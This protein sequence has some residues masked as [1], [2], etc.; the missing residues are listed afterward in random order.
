MRA[1]EQVFV[2]IPGPELDAES[3]R[4]LSTL[5]PGGVVLFKRN[6]QDEEQLNELVTALRQMLPDVVLS[7][8]AEGGRVDRLQE[9]V[10]PAPAASRLARFAPSYSLQAGR[11]VAQ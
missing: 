5:R 1:A 11:W 7:I 10:G 6:L 8:D 3:S 9:V 4:L 2:G